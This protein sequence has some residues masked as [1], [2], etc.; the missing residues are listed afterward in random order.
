MKKIIAI[1]LLVAV[2]SLGLNYASFAG[3]LTDYEVDTAE[4]GWGFLHSDRKH[5]GT[6]T[7]TY[8]YDT[9]A[10]YNKYSQHMEDAV[11]LWGDSIS[12]T[13]DA[14]STQGIVKVT[15]QRYSAD[16]S[17]V[18]ALVGDEVV[19]DNHISSY[20]LLIFDVNMNQIESY[21]WKYVLAHEIGHAYGLYHVSDDSQI[22]YSPYDASTAIH[23]ITDKDKIGMDIMT[24]SHT[25]STSTSLNCTNVN[26]SS[27]HTTKCSTC[28]ATYHQAHT[29][30]TSAYD[31]TYHKKTC[32]KCKYYEL[33]THMS[34][35]ASQYNT[36]YHTSTCAVCGEIYLESHRAYVNLG[37]GECAK[38]GYEG[39]TTLYSKPLDQYDN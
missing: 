2:M 32:S 13:Y 18:L 27:Y 12:M 33:F 3:S 37:T 6:K 30:T 16:G 26:Q 28:K 10:I 31:D 36:S 11:R 17:I 9:V 24:H 21:H 15:N 5:M 1:M 8:K 20:T 25:H 22:M 35:R 19:V 34:L 14:T 7:S 4:A 39:P 38:C 29:Y 23:P